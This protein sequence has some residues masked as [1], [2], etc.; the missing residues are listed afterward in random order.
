MSL[1]LINRVKYTPW[2]YHCWNFG[3]SL[4]VNILKVFV[5]PKKNLIVFVSFGGKRFDDSPRCIYEE[6]LIDKRF[7]GFDL[8]WAFIQPEKFDVGRAHKVKIDTFEYYITLLQAACW[9]TNS[10]VERGLNFRRKDVFYLNT[11]HGVP[12]KKMGSDI[13]ATNKSFKSKSKGEY[14]PYSVFTVNGNYDAKIFE[15]VFSL[16]PNAIKIVG[17]PRNDA[18]SCDNNEVELLKKKLKLDRVKK[19]IL[20]AP[21]FREYNKDKTDS[22]I[23][24]P[25]IDWERWEK[26]LGNDYAILFRAHYEVVKVMNIRETDFVRNVST[27]PNLNELML[28][29]DILISDYS[30]IFFDYSILG[31]PM[32]TF[33]YDYKEYSS[34]RGMYFDIRKEL[35]SD[36]S[37]Q[38]QLLES[39]KTLDVEKA[40]KRALAFRR[41]FMEV[42]GDASKQC[43]DLIYDNIKEK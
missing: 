18:L 13:A 1:S 20:Y 11:W 27:Y 10:S 2:L 31:R 17:L 8:V 38:D 37:T 23:I 34:K 16:A 36:N 30:S 7:D 40:I 41:K 3:G 43:V 25:P 21:T 32:L 33:C 42:Y 24:A 19:V 39:I 9:V 35:D 12:I 22:C 5:K 15:R 14:A 4:V 26:E 29:S 6:I 28:V